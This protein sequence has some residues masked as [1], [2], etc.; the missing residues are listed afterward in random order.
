MPAS[1]S[2]GTASI[3]PELVLGYQASR[4]SR[5][6]IHSLL[7]G[8]EAVSIRPAGPRTGTLGLFFLTEQEAD[9]AEALHAASGVFTYTSP[10][11]PTTGMRYV[12][13]GSID[14]QLDPST[15]TRWIV[16]VPYREVLL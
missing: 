9:A 5:N 14:V 4:A 13:D 11:L 12:T 7:S 8:A 3:T 1:I 10:E 2:I 6:V 16:S 15:L